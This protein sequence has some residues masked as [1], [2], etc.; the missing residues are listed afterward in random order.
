[1][2][3]L[4]LFKRKMKLTNAY[5]AINKIMRYCYANG[6]KKTSGSY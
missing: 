6:Y 1:M 3:I 5:N 4:L 2:Q